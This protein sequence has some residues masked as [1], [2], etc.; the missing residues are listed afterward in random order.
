MVGT[1]F[2]IIHNIRRKGRHSITSL[3]ITFAPVRIQGVWHDILYCWFWCCS[4][5]A[6]RGFKLETGTSLPNHVLLSRRMYRYIRNTIRRIS[7]R[8]YLLNGSAGGCLGKLYLP[9]WWCLSFPRVS[10]VIWKYPRVDVIYGVFPCIGKGTGALVFA[11]IVDK[12]A[13]FLLLCNWGATIGKTLAQYKELSHQIKIVLESIVFGNCNFALLLTPFLTSPSKY[14]WVNCIY[15]GYQLRILQ[16]VGT[17]AEII[18]KLPQFSF[19]WLWLALY[20]LT[21][22]QSAVTCTEQLKSLQFTI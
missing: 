7:M 18:N 6:I 14:L 13:Q 20:A 3:I 1:A 19:I 11:T 2:W 21:R 16:F 9:L 17:P 5:I 12:I 4:W 8:P 10:F 15:V 22:W